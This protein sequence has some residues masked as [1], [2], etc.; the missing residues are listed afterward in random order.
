[1][2]NTVD[3]VTSR[4]A[5]FD[6]VE[7]VAKSRNNNSK[8][9]IQTESHVYDS[10]VKRCTESVSDT[11]IRDMTIYAI[12]FLQA[13]HLPESKV[14][15]S[16]QLKEINTH[17]VV[18]INSVSDLEQ[19]LYNM[20]VFD[21]LRGAWQSVKITNGDLDDICE[22]DFASIEMK[23]TLS[24]LRGLE[25]DETVEVPVVAKLRAKPNL[26]QVL[27]ETTEFCSVINGGT[28]GEAIKEIQQIQKQG[29]DD[30]TKTALV[31]GLEEIYPEGAILS[32]RHEADGKCCE[33]LVVMR[34]S[35]SFW[36]HP[37]DWYSP[38]YG[39]N[40]SLGLSRDI[41]E[42]Y[43]YHLRSSHIYDKIRDE[44][45]KQVA[46]KT[47]RFVFVGHSQGG[48]VATLLAKRF[49]KDHLLK[50]SGIFLYTFGSPTPLRNA[51]DAYKL[52]GVRHYRFIN[53]WDP[54][55]EALRVFNPEYCHFGAANP[56]P[57]KSCSVVSA[58]N[59]QTYENNIKAEAS[60][61]ETNYIGNYITTL[62]PHL[63]TG[64]SCRSSILTTVALTTAAA[65][66][67]RNREAFTSIAKC[68]FGGI[69]SRL[70]KWR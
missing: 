68:A 10:A 58:H 7:E 14:A 46:N 32:I 50:V 40:L 21:V 5:A 1:M 52:S 70:S 44:V 63:W 54:V 20:L 62:T 15:V 36:G 61:M 25:V 35:K 57:L 67:F 26:Y 49:E 37:G 66:C 8:N 51:P 59:I 11:S 29:K 53:E 33:V 55:P 6:I 9:G 13:G 38:E 43:G 18:P 47:V 69:K 3:I 27:K 41:P 22:A 30:S 31:Q 64:E 4:K 2:D 17:I 12:K 23:I 28:K 56:L 19:R 39:G 16:E 24:Y 48:A 34:G 45:S 60:S 65:I 42:H